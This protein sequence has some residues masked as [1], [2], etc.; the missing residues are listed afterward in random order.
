MDTS[1]TVES[2]T[3]FFTATGGS[4][5]ALTGLLAL[6]YVYRSES[7]RE[8]MERAVNQLHQ[9]L[10]RK[11]SGSEPISANLSIE[12]LATELGK[13][14]DRFSPEDHKTIMGVCALMSE[15]GKSAASF[16][17]KFQRSN[18]LAIA[19]LALAI[20]F[21]ALPFPA[22]QSF[23]QVLVALG[24]VLAVA[25]LV[26]AVLFISELTQEEHHYHIDTK[27]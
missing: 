15:L 7:V 17:K 24:C 14:G 11:K 5:G 9:L 8:N 26:A 20:I 2:F 21:L 25:G 4:F 10:L 22:V 6:V 1:I 18:Y 3:A 16:K 13:F 27:D 23:G 12:T 19:N